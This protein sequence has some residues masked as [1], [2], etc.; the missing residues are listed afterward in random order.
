MNQDAL[1]LD[2]TSIHRVVVV[3]LVI[4]QFVL[5]FCSIIMLISYQAYH[6][7]FIPYPSMTDTGST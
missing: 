7:P 3:S 4:T 2:L 1:Q 5:F 6:L